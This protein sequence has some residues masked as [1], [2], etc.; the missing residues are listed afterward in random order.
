MRC[1]FAGAIQCI[2]R[3]EANWNGVVAA[4][5]YQFLNAWSGRSFGDE[6]FIKWPA[7]A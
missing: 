7:R 6:Y 2:A 5:L 1:A 3:L 4:Q